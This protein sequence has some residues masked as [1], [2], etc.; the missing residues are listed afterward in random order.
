MALFR[1]NGFTLEKQKDQLKAILLQGAL[2]MKKV[3]MVWLEN[4]QKFMTPL[5][6]T[7]VNVLKR[8]NNLLPIQKV[9]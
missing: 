2:D 4:I 9:K 1:P 7:L 6:N 8:K 3:K 5:K